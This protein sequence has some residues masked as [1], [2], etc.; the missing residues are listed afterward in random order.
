M[1]IYFI[2][3]FYRYMNKLSTNNNINF[4]SVQ[5]ASNAIASAAISPFSPLLTKMLNEK[6]NRPADSF[7][8]AQEG[9]AQTSIQQSSNE[10]RLKILYIN[11]FH[12]NTDAISG[13]SSGVKLTQRALQTTFNQPNTATFVVSGGD[14]VAGGNLD[15]N[16]M[17]FDFMINQMK[18]GYSAV[19]NH[20]MDA[21]LESFIEE[22]KDK[23]ISFIATNVE[24][25]DEEKVRKYIKKSQIV[26]QNGSKYGFVGAMPQDFLS[27]TK[28]DAQKGLEVDDFDDTVEHLQEEINKLKSQGVNKII[29]LSHSGHEMDK[30]LASA[31]DGID[32]IIGGHT[33]TVVEGAKKGENLV[34]SKSGEPVIITQ[35]GENGRFFGLLDVVFNNNGVITKVDNN[36]IASNNQK[37]SPVIETLKGRFIGSIERV[38]ALKQVD[39][40]PKNRRKEPCAWTDF[41]AD[42]IREEMGVQVAIVNAA[43]TRKVPQEGTLTNLDVSESTPMKNKLLRTTVTQKQL[44]DAIKQAARETMNSE[45]GEPGLLHVSGLRYKIDKQGNLLEATFIGNGKEEKIDVNNPSSS[46]TYSASYDN[47]VAS[48]NGE[49]PLLAPSKNTKV[50]NFDFDKDETLLR[51]IAKKEDKDSL[52]ITDDKRIEIV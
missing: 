13:M 48:E 41:I 43:N 8:R 35:T 17:V 31:I 18:I 45:N 16:K 12:G 22:I 33:H 39:P 30:K 6:Y 47:F 44:I 5:T 49:T 23:K 52:I 9:Q 28:K 11:D 10:D 1:A 37:K 21:G 20:E 40:M 4:K 27:C 50:E 26:E 34:S 32:V 3:W 7:E 15:K 51:F 46:I 24:F 38:G 14:N 29:L 42:S 25:E 36:L 2:Q 19:G